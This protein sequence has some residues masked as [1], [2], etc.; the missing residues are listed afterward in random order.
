MC[1]NDY[2]NPFNPEK[3]YIN[4]IVSLHSHF[5]FKVKSVYRSTYS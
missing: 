3:I 2:N 5:Y 1:S 4:M